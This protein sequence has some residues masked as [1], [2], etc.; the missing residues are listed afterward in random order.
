M[1]FNDSMYMYETK[2]RPDVNK[3]RTVYICARV[4]HRGYSG[5]YLSESGQLVRVGGVE[6]HLL[7]VALGHAADRVH[8]RARA[9]V[10]RHVPTKGLIHIRTAC[11]TVKTYNS[12]RREEKSMYLAL[13]G[14][15]CDLES[16]AATWSTG[17]PAPS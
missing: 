15:P 11:R 8:V 17:R 10:L 3:M 2:R 14:S 16:T 5:G 12:S 13:E 1:F 9:I 4:S 7:Q 6:Q